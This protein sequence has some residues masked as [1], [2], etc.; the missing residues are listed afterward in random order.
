MNQHLLPIR[1]RIRSES[2]AKYS[3]DL[4]VNSLLNK[5]GRLVVNKELGLHESAKLIRDA[6]RRKYLFHGVVKFW[7]V[8][9]FSA[10]GCIM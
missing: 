3:P 2:P 1:V 9:I 4:C 10:L 7:F 6:I 5:S 8:A